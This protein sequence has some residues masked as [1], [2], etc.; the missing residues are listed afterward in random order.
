MRIRS[1][2]Q[3]ERILAEETETNKNN[4]SMDPQ[5]DEELINYKMA[6][7]NISQCEKNYQMK[8]VA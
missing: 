7:F 4:K 3:F 5:N 2:S 6:E 8:L 1:T